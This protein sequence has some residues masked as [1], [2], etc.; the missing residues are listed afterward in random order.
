MELDYLTGGEKRKQQQAQECASKRRKKEYIY[1]WR[2]AGWSRE[3]GAGGGWRGQGGKGTG[4]TGDR[5]PIMSLS[6]AAKAEHALVVTF[7]HV[8]A[9]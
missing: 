4:A 8:C 7:S 2:G 1:V 9:R 5:G 3:T 6:V